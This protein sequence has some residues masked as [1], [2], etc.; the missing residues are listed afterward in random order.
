M[1]KYL[2][3]FIQLLLIFSVKAQSII[4]VV[5]NEETKAPVP[6]AT[7]RIVDTDDGV[8]SDSEGHFL[9]HNS[10]RGPIKIEVSC[11]GFETKVISVNITPSNDLILHLTPSHFE[12]KELVVSA[13]S[14]KLDDVSVVNVS[15]KSLS[16]PSIENASSLVTS[17]STIPGVDQISTGTGIGKP[18]IRGL[19]GSRVVVYTQN[20][21]LE[22][23]QFGDE[24]G[25]GENG[26]G[27][28]R[29]E[30]IKGPAS[31]L[32]GADA[33]GGVIY[34]VDEK[35][36][37][38]NETNGF[39]ESQY[40]TNAKTISNQFGVKT[41]KEGLKWNIFGNYNSS[42]DYELPNGK[43]TLNSRFDELA[44]KSSLGLSKENWLMNV[45]YGY[46]LNDFGIPEGD[47]TS[48]SKRAKMLPFQH[49]SQHNVSLEN[50]LFFGQKDVTLVLG[51]SANNR[52]EFEESGSFAEL[53][54]S[55]KT[56]TYQLKSSITTLSE[57][58]NLILGLQGM[59]S[60]NSN[61][62]EDI[63]I[64]DASTNDFGGYTLLSV[65]P[66]KDL[67]F[68]GGVRG[69]IRWLNTVAYSDMDK[70]IQ[71]LDRTFKS[72]NFSFGSS[73]E[74][75]KFTFRAN[76][77]TGYRPPNTAELLSNGVHEGTLRYE[78][79]DPKL[80]DENATQTD[81]SLVYEN[82]HIR[83]GINPFYNN[84]DNYIFLSPT[85]GNI[86]GVNSYQ[87]EQSNAQLWGGEIGIHFHPH[88]IHWLHLEGN[89]SRIK[90]KD[91]SGNPLPMIPANRLTSK[92]SSE[93]FLNKREISGSV[94][95][96]LVQ[97]FKQNRVAPEETISHGYGL[98]NFGMNLDRKKS[99]WQ[100]GISNLFNTEYVDHLSRLKMEEIW[101]PGRNMFIRFKLKF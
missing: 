84:I 99:Q 73:Y 46:L 43:R 36:A 86:D 13:P 60:K 76:I 38:R 77:S 12:L 74:F 7:V 64:P 95:L 83:I 75:S 92:V 52:E 53:D 16:N 58:S 93:L 37:N 61:G 30:V 65:N 8:I 24:H 49:I 89:Y 55:L 45:R 70:T 91:A 20:I 11:V 67:T 71:Q 34:F 87:Y 94:Y 44:I 17:L 28:S 79:G 18:V 96:E 23:Q 22:N 41:N 63:L 82:K 50:S 5:I 40:M 1:I 32:Y 4:G 56:F 68:Q 19:S 51:Y 9:I 80:I 48:N 2:F 47:I 42:I 29:V 33:L 85:G 59:S 101:N 21:R 26:I 27:I 10:R 100:L 66:N 3:V 57:K 72:M 90:A 25:L 31:L 98:I 88:I 14:G 69:D 39:F 81:V 35:Y 54:M 15:H 62:G 6:Y 78:L 97:K